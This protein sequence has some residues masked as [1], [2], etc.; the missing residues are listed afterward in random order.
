MPL[1]L[2]TSKPGTS[3]SISSA[4]LVRHDLVKT[5]LWSRF[6]SGGSDVIILP[7]VVKRSIRGFTRTPS[8]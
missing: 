8:W 6:C 3:A 5:I 2:L 7:V 4:R 1:H